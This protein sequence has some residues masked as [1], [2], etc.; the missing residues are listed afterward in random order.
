MIQWF[1]L[2]GTERTFEFQSSCH[3][4]GHQLPDLVLDQAVQDPIQPGIEHFQVWS[5]HNLSGQPV[6]AP[7]HSHSKELPLTSNVNLSSLSSKPFLLVLSLSTLKAHFPPVNDEDVEKHQT[8]D[9]PLGDTVHHQLPHRHRDILPQ[10]SVYGLPTNSFIH[11]I[12]HP[13]NP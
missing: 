10:N 2:E 6:S 13:S 3:R 8:Q 7:Y 1:G 12:V 11:W 9:S 5:I 4:Q